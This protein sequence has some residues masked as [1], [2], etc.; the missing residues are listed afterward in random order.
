MRMEKRKQVKY[1]QLG[2]QD[3]CLIS[4][5]FRVALF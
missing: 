5:R 1:V 3:L 2:I 4:D